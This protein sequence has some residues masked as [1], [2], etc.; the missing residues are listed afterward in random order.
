MTQLLDSKN[1]PINNRKQRRIQTLLDDQQMSSMMEMVREETEKV[2]LALPDKQKDIKRKKDCNQMRSLYLRAMNIDGYNKPLGQLLQEFEHYAYN[3][4]FDVEPT[5]DNIIIVSAA[6]KNWIKTGF[7]ICFEKAKRVQEACLWDI[8]ET[9]GMAC[10]KIVS[11]YLRYLDLPKIFSCLGMKAQSLWSS[12]TGAIAGSIVSTATK[13]TSDFI[14]VCWESV[15]SFFHTIFEKIKEALSSVGIAGITLM[16]VALA[17]VI[18]IIYE[19][20]WGWALKQLYSY[21]F[22]SEIKNDTVMKAQGGEYIKSFVATSIAGWSDFKGFTADTR[23]VAQFFLDLSHIKNFF[24]S[25]IEFVTTLVDQAWTY[26]FGAPLTFGGKEFQ[27]LVDAH[28][29][30]SELSLTGT[31]PEL[32]ANKK[33]RD[34][35]HDAYLLLSRVQATQRP[36]E[37]AAKE[38]RDRVNATLRTY[39]EWFL[40]CKVSKTRER[41]C[42]SRR[43]PPWLYLHGDAGAGKTVFINIFL[44]Y[45]LRFKKNRVYSSNDRYDRKHESFWSGYQNQFALVIDDLFQQTDPKERSVTATEMIYLANSAAYPLE[46]A[47]LDDKGNTFMTSEVIVTSTNDKSFPNVSI[48]NLKAL[49]RRYLAV[50]LKWNKDI[51]AKSKMDVP[52]LDT[53]YTFTV[54]KCTK[55]NGVWAYNSKFDLK[56][57]ELIE[58]F[59]QFDQT[60]NDSSPSTFDIDIG[61]STPPV[62]PSNGFSSSDSDDDGPMD[63]DDDDNNVLDPTSFT[64]I[65]GSSFNSRV[66]KDKFEAKKYTMAV[67]KGPNPDDLFNIPEMSYT[68]LSNNKKFTALLDSLTGPMR[69]FYMDMFEHVKSALGT[70]DFQRLANAYEQFL[71]AHLQIYTPRPAK[72][73]GDYFFERQYEIFISSIGPMK[74]QGI[75]GTLYDL[76]FVDP[77]EVLAKALD[78]FHE[79]SITAEDLKSL[80]VALRASKNSSYIMTGKILC[81]IRNIFHLQQWLLG[82]LSYDRAPYFGLNAANTNRLA[83]MIMEAHDC[84]SMT[85]F[86][87]VFLVPPYKVACPHKSK[88]ININATFDDLDPD[89]AEAILSYIKD[90]HPNCYDACRARYEIKKVQYHIDTRNMYFKIAAIA[91]AGVAILV[92]IGFTIFA[93]VE[94]FTGRKLD[95][96][97]QSSNPQMRKFERMWNKRQQVKPMVAQSADFPFTDLAVK[98]Y[99][100]NRLLRITHADGGVMYSIVTFLR[101]RLAVAASHSFTCGKIKSIEMYVTLSPSAESTLFENYEYTL[102]HE[103]ERDLVFIAFDGSRLNAFKDL[104]AHL[105]DGPLTEYEG[106]TRISITDDCSQLWLV[107]ALTCTPMS[108]GATYASD[109]GTITNTDVLLA[110]GCEGVAGDCGFAYCLKGSSQPTKLVGIHVA[111]NKESSYVARIYKKDLKYDPHKKTEPIFTAQSVG[112]LIYSKFTIQNDDV[113]DLG[114]IPL[115]VISKLNVTPYQPSTTSLKPTMFQTG[116]LIEVGSSVER[117]ECPFRLTTAPANLKRTKTYDPVIPALKGL[118]NKKRLPM[119]QGFDDIELWEGVYP[120]KATPRIWSDYEAVNGIVGRFPSLPSNTSSA[121]PYALKGIKRETLIKLG[122]KDNFIHPDVQAEITEFYDMAEHGTMKMPIFMEFLK[123]EKRPIE[124]VDLPRAVFNCPLWLLILFRKFLGWWLLAVNEDMDCDIR[125][126][127]NPYSNDWYEDYKKFEAYGVF[128]HIIAHDVSKWD[129]HFQLFFADAKYNT[130]VKRYSLDK[131]FSAFELRCLYFIIRCHFSFALLIDYLLYLADFMPSGGPGTAHFN[132]SYN[133]VKSRWILRKIVRESFECQK[134]DFSFAPVTTFSIGRYFGDDSFIGIS[135]IVLKTGILLT[136]IITPQ[137]VAEYGNKYFDH[138]HTTANKKAITEYD[139]I[140]T[141]EFLKRKFV[142]RDGHVMCPINLESI[143]QSLLWYDSSSELSYNKQM[144]INAHGAIREAFF[145]GKDVF[146]HYKSVIN[147]F[148]NSIGADNMFH[149]SYETMLRGLVMSRRSN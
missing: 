121:F 19:I 77:F 142:K 16:T 8:H 84:K 110:K 134:A 39:K 25:I 51:P 21:L 135:P 47:S 59:I 116:T 79:L 31:L 38:F 36:V 141:A 118:I 108:K 76:S 49:H 62:P 111:G 70:N 106:I 104:E 80:G 97:S 109:N 138:Q 103:E 137:L 129:Q 75:F 56:F 69:Q 123:D 101:D 147:P 145:H 86:P 2:T 58:E 29:T 50:S 132:S 98:I 102:H 130:L 40:A 11:K 26:V 85:L 114:K 4:G 94:T 95:M 100:N 78:H 45:W 72:I 28:K 52:Y 148:L 139:T 73:S 6:I 126:G 65:D 149:D 9:R 74:A 127:V 125:I 119:P 32:L 46:M 10:R 1:F 33:D 113:F 88:F 90:E 18:W 87:S 120:K 117:L 67:Y 43:Q 63:D 140:E 14:Q 5:R 82:C 64:S 12:M 133:S 27:G 124:K 15:K 144:T 41:N 136:T 92:G 55:I 68:D 122:A 53:M 35:F 54:S 128:K 112:G 42:A 146:E 96:M 99:K 131:I 23:S 105:P 107:P 143:E 48:T 57:S 17:F 34:S 24:I 91:T 7:L 3:L 81:N 83:M 30:F 93:L 89:E 61:P 60:N 13:K 37:G 44:S 66:A 22:T 71:R 115:P 20:G